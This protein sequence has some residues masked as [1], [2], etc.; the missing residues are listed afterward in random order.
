MINK[1][2]AVKANCLNRYDSALLDKRY[3]SVPVLLYT[4][5]ILTR[6]SSITAAHITLSPL[7]L[8]SSAC[9][10]LLWAVSYQLSAIRFQNFFVYYFEFQVSRLTIHH[11]LLSIHHSSSQFPHRFFKLPPPVF[12][13]FEQV[14]TCT[15]RTQQHH[16]SFI[17]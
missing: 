4:T 17:C 2:T 13:V 14:K 9:M 11:S 3:A 5:S 10:F 6:V 15:G 7:V 12:V 1:P 16:I 8:F